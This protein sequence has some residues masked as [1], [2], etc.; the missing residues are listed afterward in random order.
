MDPSL[1]TARTARNSQSSS[2]PQHVIQHPPTL[3]HIIPMRAQAAN[4]RMTAA[5]WTMREA[6]KKSW[7]TGCQTSMVLAWT[8]QER[9]ARQSRLRFS[10]KA[11]AI[12]VHRRR[13]VCANKIQKHMRK[14]TQMRSKSLR[15]ATVMTSDLDGGAM[16]DIWFGLADV[17]QG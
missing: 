16:M 15:T 11:L 13:R 1:T 12:G 7:T 5:P 17:A 3:K 2:K 9:S 14:C 4:V 10:R 8:R 6:Q